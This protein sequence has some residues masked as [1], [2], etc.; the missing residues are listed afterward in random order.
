MTN[1]ASAVRL[2]MRLSQIS[3]ARAR[4]AVG[5]DGN[6]DILKALKDAEVGWDR[7][8]N[9][10]AE[11][12]RSAKIFLKR[13]SLFYID[14]GLRHPEPRPV[15]HLFMKTRPAARALTRPLKT[16]IGGNHFVSLC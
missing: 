9:K 2:P 7:A 16:A 3:L 5:H 14:S 1:I 4:E 15:N 10:I 12:G 13:L 11:R 8:V 6:G